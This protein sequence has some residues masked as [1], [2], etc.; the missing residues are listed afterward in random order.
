MRFKQDQAYRTCKKHVEK[1][2]LSEI[3]VQSHCVACKVLYHKL[4]DFSGLTS[5]EQ[6]VKIQE[7]AQYILCNHPHKL[8][9]SAKV[10]IL[11]I[12]RWFP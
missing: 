11:S 12:F 10:Y 7:F 9:P 4:K 3:S 1:P 8:C 6:S 5:E 2:E